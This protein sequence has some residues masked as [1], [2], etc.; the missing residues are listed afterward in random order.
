MGSIKS[1]ILDLQNN[2]NMEIPSA[3]PRKH[4][5]VNHK[6]H[7]LA[8]IWLLKSFLKKPITTKQTFGP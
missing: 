8:T 7:F 2:S 1:L 4:F 6:T 3:A 5:A